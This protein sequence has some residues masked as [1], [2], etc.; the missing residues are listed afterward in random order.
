MR[1]LDVTIVIPTRN[2]RTSLDRALRALG[3][4]HF[5]PSR[6]EAIVAVDGP[7]DGTPVHVAA[8]DL[9]FQTTVTTSDLPRGAGAAR[10]QGAAAAS[11]DLLV[12]LDDD[13]EPGPDLVGAH[14]AA[15]RQ[16]AQVTIGYLP[17]AFESGR[18]PGFFQAA[19]RGWWE[20]MFAE[21]RQ[22]GH[23]YRFRD[24]LTGNCAMRATLFEQTGGFDAA[25][26][27]HEDYELGVRLLASGAMFRYE[28]ASRGVHHERTT[29]GRSFNRKL[30]EGR[31]DVLMLE[32][33]PELL[34]VLPL[35]LLDTHATRLERFLKRLAFERPRA[36]RLLSAT[37]ARLLPS[38]ERARLRGRWTR[39]LNDLLSGWY[40][41]G[42]AGRLP[43]LAALEE[44]RGAC[45]SRSTW[46][47][48]VLEVD[49][50]N[51]LE[52]VMA[53]V[54]RR[55]PAGLRVAYERQVI[56]EIPPVPGAEALT[57]AHLRAA[58]ARE[59]AG[60]FV[61]ALGRAGAVAVQPGKRGPEAT[62][63]LPADTVRF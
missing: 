52:L 38:L 62:G 45:R 13:I 50:A 33:H 5:A 19:L 28:E 57:G 49:V 32:K 54:D 60:P 6:F 31:A 8:L 3:H 22:E 34:P 11:G 43:S 9:P 16:G 55:R 48:L 4:Q 44:F 29:V 61:A 42:V 36:G 40:W 37:L 21:M 51:G 14:V 15:H 27:C 26:G 24:L 46:A 18:P 39:L 25:F 1:S 10:N 63:P 7:D 58:L 59:L 30:D 12:F 53:Q 20:A 23:R 47:P 56:G 2:R 35:T 17:P 41:T